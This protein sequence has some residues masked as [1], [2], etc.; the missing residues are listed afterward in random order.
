MDRWIDGQM[1]RWKDGQMDGQ[2]DRQIDR[3]ID[4]YIY[5]CV[6]DLYDMRV[7]GLWDGWYGI[8]VNPTSKQ[9]FDVFS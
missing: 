7:V 4:V 9:N 5:T 2:I 8:W 1:N 3:Q 6:C